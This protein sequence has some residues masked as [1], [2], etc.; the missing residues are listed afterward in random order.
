LFLQELYTTNGT[1]LSD[2]KSNS[3]QLKVIEQKI[4]DKTQQL[5]QPTT[6]AGT[7]QL[8]RHEMDLEKA[9]T[10]DRDSTKVFR[11]LVRDK[12]TDSV[13]PDH[14][15][16]HLDQ[17]WTEVLSSKPTCRRRKR[18]RGAAAITSDSRSCETSTK[19]GGG[20]AS[21]EAVSKCLQ[22]EEASDSIPSHERLQPSSSDHSKPLKGN[23][24]PVPVEVIERYRLSVEQ[25]KQ[26]PRFQNYSVGTPTAVCSLFFCYF[27]V[28]DFCCCKYEQFVY[29]VRVRII[30]TYNQ[31]I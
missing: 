15:I 23:I 16:N 12:L 10:Q 1:C 4:A 28:M 2:L 22:R 24:E 3:E 30:L 8:S 9:V 7:K 31:L 18:K 25:I 14:P 13:D 6:F 29:L 5:S 27:I 20:S 17:I 21:E 19:V 11:C 26:L